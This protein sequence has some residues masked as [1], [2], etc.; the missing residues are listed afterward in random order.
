MKLL[1]R[2]AKVTCFVFDVDGVLTD[3]GLLLLEDGQMA[4][5]MNIKDGY[6]LQLAIKKGYRVLAISGG[7]S[8][9]VKQ[10]LARLGVVDVFLKVENKKQLL[11]DYLQENKI[12]QKEVLYMGDDIPDYE[13]MREA[14]LSCCPADAA[15]EIK[16]IATYISGLNGGAGCVREIIEK[17]LKQ[18]GDWGLVTGITSR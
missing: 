2:F 16:Q 8:E 3:G 15:P 7:N 4:R 18:R 1:E 9:A 13:V 10:R 6:A 11:L 17:V 12:D 14:G 5:Q